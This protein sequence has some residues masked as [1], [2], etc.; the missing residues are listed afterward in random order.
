MT[1]TANEQTL[2]AQTTTLDGA[3]I[4]LRL[5]EK[6]VPNEPIERDTGAPPLPPRLLAGI[7]SMSGH[8]MSD[9]EVHEHSPM[10]ASL[11]ALAFT[12]GS[13]I[14]LAPGQEHHLP[15]EAWHA[16]QQ[17]SGRVAAGPMATTHNQ[18]INDDSAL[19]RE[20]DVMG[21]RAEKHEQ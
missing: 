5:K 16:A 12:Q 2:K 7:E 3:S 18:P 10:P 17:T 11:G 6:Y 4:D 13:Q 19:E 15:H 8:D 14:H 21:Q 9:V 1:L 20:A